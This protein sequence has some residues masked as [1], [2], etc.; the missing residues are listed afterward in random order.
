M[1]PPA[2][3]SAAPAPARLDPRFFFP[4][5]DALRFLVWIPSFLM[6]SGRFTCKKGDPGLAAPALCTDKSGLGTAS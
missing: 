2:G 5:P 4:F 6:V 3:P 1:K